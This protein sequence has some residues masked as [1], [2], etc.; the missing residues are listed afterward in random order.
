MVTY[1]LDLSGLKEVQAALKVAARSDNYVEVGLHEPDLAQIG[2]YNEYGTATAPPR[3]FVRASVELNENKYKSMMAKQANQLIQ[4]GGSLEL[5]S[6]GQ[7]ASD[8]MQAYAEDLKEPKNAP[9]TIKAKGFD[10]PLINTG[11][12]VDS[13]TFKVVNDDDAL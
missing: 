7:E 1:D 4:N 12:M 10:N 2:Y 11:E 9:S 13:I 8:D 6:I 5:S 3:P